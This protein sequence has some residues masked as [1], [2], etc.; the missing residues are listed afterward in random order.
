MI[1][2]YLFPPIFGIRLGTLIT[3]RLLNVSTFKLLNKREN[4]LAPYAILS[5]TLARDEDEVTLQDMQS[6]AASRSG[7]DITT[8]PVSLKSGFAKIREAARLALSQGLE[9]IWVDTCN[10]D[11][12]SSAEL[13]EAINSIF[14][15]YKR[16]AACYAL[17]SD[18]EGTSNSDTASIGDSLSFDENVI[19]ALR[20]SRW[21]RRGWT[22]QEAS[23]S[24]QRPVI[25]SRPELPRN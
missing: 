22:L 12:T 4:E 18:V 3:M 8:S 23:C 9:F 25:L 17:L 16:S 5:H 14:S 1:Q 19:Q 10:I 11:K 13:S 24:Q 21:F 15:W 2:N 20:S 7:E 6:F